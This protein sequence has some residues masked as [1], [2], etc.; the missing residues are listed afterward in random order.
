MSPRHRIPLAPAHRIA[1]SARASTAGRR[2]ASGAALGTVVAPPPGEESLWVELDT[3]QVVPQCFGDDT[4]PP[5]ARV[6]CWWINEGHELAV[7]ATTGGAYVPPVETVQPEVLYPF[8][9]SFSD[10][11]GGYGDASSTYPWEWAGGG[12]A[13]IR[14]QPYP[15]PG[16][17]ITTPYTVSGSDWTVAVCFG[18]NNVPIGVYS[19][20]HLLKIG[21]DIISIY[22][23][24]SEQS[25]VLFN[26]VHVANLP[27]YAHYAQRSVLTIVSSGGLWLNDQQIA[28]LS[29]LGGGAL[30]IGDETYGWPFWLFVNHLAAWTE[31]LDFA[32]IASLYSY[33]PSGLS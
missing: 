20:V 27:F 30:S 17:H 1:G 19:F 29:G 28:T 7:L 18:R 2:A 4:L 24:G 23:N 10:Q 3:G 15:V 25:W 21:A 32:A 14:S 16:L 31:E 6:L 8:A 9:G 33:I 22:K 13:G 26:G 11:L 5:G 12:I